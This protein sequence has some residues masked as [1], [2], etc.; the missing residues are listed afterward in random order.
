LAAYDNAVRD[1]KDAVLQV[2]GFRRQMGDPT[3]DPM[4]VAEKSIRAKEE[5]ARL[6]STSRGG[7]SLTN[8]NTEAIITP[9]TVYPGKYR[10]SYID[11]RSRE[12]MGDT[13][14][15]ETMEAAI[16]DAMDQG[17]VTLERF[18]PQ[19]FANGGGVASLNEIARGMFR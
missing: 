2:E 11:R 8:R 5:A 15:F 18:D 1:A 17:Y 10:I 14:G 19:N 4:A 9:S 12:P 16:K 3:F 7:V 13:E 6:L